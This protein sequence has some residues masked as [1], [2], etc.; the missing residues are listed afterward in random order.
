MDVDESPG[1]FFLAIIVIL[2]SPVFTARGMGS[3]ASSSKTTLPSNTS[4]NIR[5]IFLGHHATRSRISV[6]HSDLPTIKK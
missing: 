1:I 2:L 3:E 5:D 6:F 4:P